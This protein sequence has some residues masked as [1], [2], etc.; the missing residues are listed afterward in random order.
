M[1]CKLKKILC[2]TIAML[3]LC[4]CGGQP[5]ET[6]D[7]PVS[8]AADRPQT[9]P[10]AQGG[11]G[12]IEYE[13]MLTA[14]FL[15]LP[16]GMVHATAQC[17][18]GYRIWLGGASDS[19]AVMGWI[20]LDGGDSGLFAM[21]EGC[22]FV[23]ALCAVGGKV[24]AMAGSVPA[25]YVDAQGK[26]VV[27]DEPEGRLELLVFEG[28]ELVSETELDGRYGQTFHSMLELD[29]SFYILC[30]NKLI[31]L[32]PDGMESARFEH[33]EH[34]VLMLSM[35]VYGGELVVAARDLNN[36]GTRFYRLDVD[37]L[38]LNGEE[39]IP[40]TIISGMGMVN[41]TLVVDTGTEVAALDGDFQ[42]GDPVFEW[43]ELFVSGGYQEID[44]LPGG[45]L[46]FDPYQTGVCC[47][48]WKQA[49]VRK[50]VI[51][52]ADTFYGEAQT[53]VGDFNRSQEEYYVEIKTY[54]AYDE[55][56][57]TRLQT[58]IGAGNWPDLFAFE[59]PR[60]LAEMRDEKSLENL[61]DYLD[62]DPE[63]P[64]EALMPQLLG[65]MERRGALYWMP[66]KF[67]VYTLIAPE[68]LVGGP[69]ISVEDTLRIA[70]ENGLVPIEQW[71]TR[72]ELLSRYS[73]AAI[74]QFVDWDSGTCSFDSEEFTNM[75]RLCGEMLKGEDVNAGE[76]YIGPR[77]PA[78][79][80]N[81]ILSN[82]IGIAALNSAYGGDYCFAGYP[83]AQG[84]GSMF[85]IP[86]RLAI[87]AGANE[88]Q[89]AWEFIKFA[90]S[91][92]EQSA[93]FSVNRGLSPNLAVFERELDTML[94]EGATNILGEKREITGDDARK[95]RELIDGTL[96][97]MDADPTLEMI[98]S[99]CAAAYFAGDKSAEDTARDIQGRAAIYVAERG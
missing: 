24:A 74:R 27:T 98:I 36:H 59:N 47:A 55:G 54:N 72:E 90:L 13:L 3:L 45:Y 18:E 35:R 89:G 32:S 31:K 19:G 43:A 41:D 52:A 97:L 5:G 92:P 26:T 6:S 64:A 14:G 51:M 4:G 42:F 78:L 53:L 99:G 88:K 15:D 96:L 76:A 65:V 79:L 1:K 85:L 30:Q 11:D 8:G 48:R 82:L 29:G 7:S 44:E 57:L 39:F 49:R 67:W 9:E 71:I 70:R 81:Y 77:D 60:T 86:L 20:S 28:T 94:R 83:G 87:T 17:R 50:T 93:E 23:Y 62:R 66:W 91:E 38:S 46:F 75:L 22:D 2:L 68:S 80:K 34:N 16:E 10:A 61:Y 21:P 33:G 37:T 73:A 25:L 12:E 84:S 58:E 95:L 56:E 63:L 40:E 69:G